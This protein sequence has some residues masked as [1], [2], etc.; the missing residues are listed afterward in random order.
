MSSLKSAKSVEVDAGKV[1]KKRLLIDLEG[2]ENVDP[3]MIENEPKKF[4]RSFHEVYL[5]FL[6]HSNVEPEDE[7]MEKKDLISPENKAKSN[8]KKV[9]VRSVVVVKKEAG[10]VEL[11]DE[12][13]SAKPKTKAQ[14][15]DIDQPSTSSFSES[16][17][18]TPKGNKRKSND[19]GRW[20]FNFLIRDPDIMKISF[21]FFSLH[22]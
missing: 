3:E 15:K 14:V 10:T 8:S 17:A 4:K 19:T 1:S 16:P 9:N 7:I 13:K 12:P 2:E 20:H 21:N 22:R 11:E 6:G 18:V 5:N